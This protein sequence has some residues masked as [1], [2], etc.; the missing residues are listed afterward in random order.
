MELLTDK[1]WTGLIQIS[2]NLKDRT[3]WWKSGVH[4]KLTW[5]YYHLTYHFQSLA[6]HIEV[7]LLSLFHF[8]LSLYLFS[9]LA[10]S[11]A[12][13]G[14]AEVKCRPPAERSNAIRRECTCP[15]AGPAHTPV[16]LT[17]HCI[18][19]PSPRIR[20]SYFTNGVSLSCSPFG[21]RNSISSFEP[22]LGNLF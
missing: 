14:R 16:V 18:P 15:A 6:V 22:P 17:Q 5:V 13:T 19:Y 3:S 2:E 9:D 8:Y 12:E 11:A 20:C 1:Q 7:V 10:C 21:S 4:Y